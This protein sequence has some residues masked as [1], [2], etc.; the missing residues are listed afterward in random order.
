MYIQ[1]NTHTHTIDRIYTHNI[2]RYINLK[3]DNNIYMYIHLLFLCDEQG[4]TFTLYENYTYIH[5]YIY[6]D[7]H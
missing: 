6:N 5:I 7:K 2:K 1:A 3:F 4:I